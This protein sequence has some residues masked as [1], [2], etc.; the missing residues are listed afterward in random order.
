MRIVKFI[1][2]ACV[3][4]VTGVIDAKAESKQ[5][6]MNTAEAHKNV[7]KGL[8]G[9]PPAPTPSCDLPPKDPSVWDKSITAG[10][11]YT[12]GNSKTSSLNL[13]SKVMRDF[14]E[15]S[16]RFEADYNYGNAADDPNSQREVTKNNFRAS[17]EYKHT[18][19]TVWFAGA[20]TSFAYDEIADL[21]YRV[22]L[23]PALGAYLIKDDKQKLSLE[24][25]PSY[26][27]E[28]LGGEQ[29]DFAA[30]R[31]ADRWTWKFSET[32]SMYQSAEYL[33]SFEDSGN[34][35]F[36]GEVGLEAALTSQVNLVLAVR[37]Y[38]INQPAE[39]RRPNDVYTLTGLKVNL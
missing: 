22:I 39:D 18:L 27:F 31:I 24:T 26:V 33:V 2:L 28:D 12:E 8:D 10:F 16:W 34:Y 3:L 23:S 30:A 4:V 37:D 13:N 9:A 32:A 5:G 19:D 6:K 25:G 20:N 1:A 7:S 15:E 21:N 35:I 14:L 36:N 17:G 11:N 29:N 38:Y